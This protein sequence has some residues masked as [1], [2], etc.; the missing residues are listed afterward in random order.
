MSIHRISET[1]QLELGTPLTFVTFSRARTAT[2]IPKEHVPQLITSGFD[3]FKALEAWSSEELNPDQGAL[4][5]RL[6][7][8]VPFNEQRGLRNPLQNICDS[9]EPVLLCHKMVKS[10]TSFCILRIVLMRLT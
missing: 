6:A 9:L 3:D 10:T 1:G 7:E 4:V 2:K 5:P 8:R